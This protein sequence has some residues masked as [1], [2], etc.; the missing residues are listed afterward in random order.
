M[1]LKANLARIRV[2]QPLN[3]RQFLKQLPADLAHRHHQ[4]FTTEK[5]ADNRWLVRCV[6]EP[7]L[8]ALEARAATP[9]TRRRAASQGDSHRARVTSGFLLVMHDQLPDTRPEVVMLNRNQCQQNFTGKSQVLVVENEENFAHR[10]TM[11]AFAAQCTGAAVSLANTDL[12]MGAGNRITS[13]LSVGWLSRYD[14]VLCG[15]DYDLGGLRMFST[16]RQRLGDNA[17]FVQ[18]AHWPDWYPQFIKT[19]ATT[20]RLLKAIELAEHLELTGLAAAFRQ[21]RHF[22]EQEMILEP[23]HAQ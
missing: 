10:D 17:V 9:D 11:L 1:S 8:A 6:D 16:L 22:M 3:Y 18:P 2:G 21:T 15:F 4:L 7:V 14:Q 5:V 19:P 13:E 23:H 12:V 20:T